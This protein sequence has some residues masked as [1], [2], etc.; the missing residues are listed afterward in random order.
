[1]AINFL[2]LQ[3]HF[4]TKNQSYVPQGMGC[5]QH[6]SRVQGGMM[7]IKLKNKKKRESKRHELVPQ[8][9]HQGTGLWPSLLSLL[10][11]LNKV[12]Y[13]DGCATDPHWWGQLLLKWWLRHSVPSSKQ[14]WLCTKISTRVILPQKPGTLFMPETGSVKI[15]YATVELYIKLNLYLAQILRR[16]L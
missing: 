12:K 2:W 9:L 11:I 10:N 16:C 3:D 8:L 13:A 14:Q 1:M 5:I 15:A 6:Q 7:G 4:P